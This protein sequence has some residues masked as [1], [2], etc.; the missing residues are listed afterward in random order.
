V[1]DNGEN[2]K[3]V[4][5]P[6]LNRAIMIDFHGAKIA[7]DAGFLLLREIDDRFRIIDPMKE[8]LEDL[9]STTHTKPSWVQMVRQR[10]YQRGAGL[11]SIIGCL[12]WKN[13]LAR[14][15]MPITWEKIHFEGN[16]CYSKSL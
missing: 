3:G 6:D 11:E 5:R 14:G 13:P 9:R 1:L 12:L 10:V 15:G 16:L 7:S 8:C 2:Q 4:I